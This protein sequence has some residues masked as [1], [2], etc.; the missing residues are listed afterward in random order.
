MKFR[1]LC[2]AGVLGWIVAVGCGPAVPPIIPIDTASVT[3][4]ATYEGQPLEDYRVYFF[5]EAAAAK[6]PA[7]GRVD[8]DG[9]FTLSVRN[10][11]DG[12]MI[13]TNK[14]WLKYDPELP[15]EIPGRE[16]GTPPPPAKVKLPKMYMSAEESGLTVEVPA[17]GLTDYKL[18]L[19]APA[20]E[21]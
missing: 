20:G 15:A 17:G 7:T 1:L 11:N 21:T 9:K 13:G 2:A 8:K 6:E 19:K 12:A 3:G 16:S 5:C 18:E 10:P 4:T 14:V